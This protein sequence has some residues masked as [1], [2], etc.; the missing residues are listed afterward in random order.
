MSSNWEKENFEKVMERL[1]NSPKIDDINLIHLKELEL[2]NNEK[3]LTFGQNGG[4]EII[5]YDQLKELYD[6]IGKTYLIKKNIIKLKKNM[7]VYL[8]FKGC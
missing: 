5:S 3:I 6:F 7:M 8:S 1:K 2:I 4:T